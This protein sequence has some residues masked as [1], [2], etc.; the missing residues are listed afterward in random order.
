MQIDTPHNL[1][2]EQNGNLQV[3]LSAIGDTFVALKANDKKI[4]TLKCI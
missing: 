1:R 2:F 4:I 3:F